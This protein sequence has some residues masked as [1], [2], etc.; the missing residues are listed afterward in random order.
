MRR[1][2][3][4]RPPARKQ[5]SA[6]GEQ[7]PAGRRAAT[8]GGQ[9]ARRLAAIQGATPDALI[10]LDL[11]GFVTAWEGAAASMFG[12]GPHEIVGAPVH[13]LVPPAR[14]ADGILAHIR[15]GAAMP[16]L[17][18][19]WRAR[20]G[21]PVDVTVALSPLRDDARRA[22]GVVAVVR[23]VGP[24]RRQERAFARLSRLYRSLSRINRA[25]VRL[26]DRETLFDEV[27]R[28]LV[29]A[30]GFASAWIGW[31]D[32]RTSRLEPVARAGSALDFIDSV[33]VYTDHRPE[34]LGP[35][36]RAFRS[37]QPYVCNDALADPATLAWRPQIERS[38]IMAWAAIPVRMEGIPVGV[39]I[40]YA[41]EAGYFTDE[42]LALLVEVAGDI[43]FALDAQK[44][45]KDGR[46]AAETVRAEQQF[47]ESMIDA[48][49][50]VAYCYDQSGRFRRWNGNFEKVT[51]YS[52]DEIARMHPLEFF[53]ERD[54]PLL[55]ARISE[56]FDSGDAFVEAPFRAKDG[57]IRP[58]F[59]TGRRVVLHGSS[60]LVGVGIDI[61]ERLSAEQAMRLSEARYRTLFEYAPDGILI[62]DMESRYLD[63][64]VSMCRMLGYSR[65]ELVGLD[66]V[67]IVAPADVDRIAP[68]L[69]DLGAGK[70]HRRE[71]TF[72][73]KDGSTFP[74]EVIATRAPDG[75]VLAMVRDITE[76]RAAERTLRDLNQTLERKVEERTMELA[77][78]LV[79][80]E[81]ADRLKSAFLATMSHEL[82]TPLNS[83]I[84]F[85]GILL[86]N[87]A[88][89]LNAEQEKQLGMVRGS[90]RHLLAL[91]NDVLD[92]SKIEAGQFQVRRE[93]LDLPGLIDRAA[94]SVRPHAER[95][96]LALDVV[97]AS[98]VGEMV[99]DARRVEQIL[100]NLLSNAIKFTD[101]G[102]VSLSATLV[103]AYRAA[104]DAVPVA[105]V[106][107]AIA[108]SGIGIKAEDM[109]QLFA[110][111]RQ[112]DSGLARQHEGTGLGL[113]ICRRLA[114][115]MG[116]EIVALSEWQRG[117]TFILTLPVG[118]S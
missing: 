8:D 79:R 27:C 54:R 45:A 43:S 10:G 107:V 63:A 11:E 2:V 102:G 95:K 99:G 37:G 5:A 62:A 31:N 32:A 82:R 15:E 111:F 20:D 96:G 25:I 60:C 87:L 49:P 35:A 48:M 58:Y 68:T 116:G 13:R 70:D 12:Y 74:A 22:V 51:G 76:R 59:F 83:I 55:R 72:R 110:P 92:I 114:A 69:D 80:A 89:P 66:A 81:N 106:R 73:R 71:W 103:P 4:V 100:L 57:T 6:G 36:G 117:S 1:G 30:G 75:H 39:L 50:G 98:E 38:G 118:E 113:S 7:R 67:A 105:A 64:N 112:L 115:I 17:D 85:T 94:G 101:R 42:E 47:S 61:S 26:T 23:D 18:S 84:G 90:A 3:V 108:D 88:G 29:E 91:I 109:D 56:V 19:I 16:P 21:T 9:A 77:S 65:E 53:E 28:A 24:V 52:R 104:P 41:R 40:V 14:R 46:D 93:R 44:R 97:V 86:Q 34:G 33:E 78:A